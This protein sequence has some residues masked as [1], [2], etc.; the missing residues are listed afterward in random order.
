MNF[1]PSKFYIGVV[2][3]FSIMLPGGIFAYFL[4]AQIGPRIFGPLLPTIKG[5]GDGWV[6]FLLAAYLLGHIV[7]L[8]GS[9]LDEIVYDPIRKLIWTKKKDTAY[10]E[11]QKVKHKYVGD[12]KGPQ[13]VNTFQWAKAVL[14]LQHPAGIV[15][16]SRYEA[17]SKFFRSI[18]VVLLFMSGN[19][20]TQ[21]Q[22]ALGW[23]FIM[24]VVLSFWRYVERRYKS[25]QQ[26]YWYVL[27]LDRL[28]KLK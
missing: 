10:A 13:I 2:D 18:V 15:E 16:V 1:E 28:G 11:A 3:F 17:D 21:G 23:G 20:F 14:V 22:S 4:Y 7:F 26:A 12:E 25:T 5:E 8:I 24:M 27:A 9:V 19:A 6:I